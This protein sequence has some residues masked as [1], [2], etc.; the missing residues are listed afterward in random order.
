MRLGTFSFD[1]LE[2]P[3]HDEMSWTSSG[4]L[5]TFAAV[6]QYATALCYGQ[7]AQPNQKGSKIAYL[8][9]VPKSRP[10]TRV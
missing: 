6:S 10:I 4:P 5:D 2:R 8:Y 7:L 1:A 3:G 9:V